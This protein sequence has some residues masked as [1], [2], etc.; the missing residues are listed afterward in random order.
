[1]AGGGRSCSVHA[2]AVVVGGDSDS[3]PTMMVAFDSTS[4]EA[5]RKDEGATGERNELMVHGWELTTFSIAQVWS[6]ER[7]RYTGR[8]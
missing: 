1:M 7:W 3:R 2:Q 6:G 4:E 5:S 8:E